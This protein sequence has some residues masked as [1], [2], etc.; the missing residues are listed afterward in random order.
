[1]FLGLMTYLDPK[2]SRGTTAC[3]ETGGHREG[4][5][6]GLS[7]DPRD[8]ENC[9]DWLK[10]SLQL[11]QSWTSAGKTHETGVMSC[12]GIPML[13]TQ[14]PGYETSPSEGGEGDERDS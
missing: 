12:D 5:E 9:L 14:P 10:P 4:V 8:M 11:M 13:P 6:D 2:G 1:M 3:Q 7:G